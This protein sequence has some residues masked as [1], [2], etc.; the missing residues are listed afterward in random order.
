MCGIVG[1]ASPK[2]IKSKEWLKGSRDLLTY[3]GPD[4]SGEW[5]S[6]DC[7][8]GFGHRRLS[9]IDTSKAGHQPMSDS[10]GLIHIVFNG[11]I[12]NFLEL[13]EEL[14]LLNENFQS[15]TD[16]EVILMAYKVW[17]TDCLSR[18]NG[19]FAFAIFDSI[20]N[21]IFIARDRIGEK[22]L[23]YKVSKGELKF[24][25]EVK[26]LTFDSTITKKINPDAFDLFLTFGYVPGD[27]SMIDGIKK[28]PPAHALIF[29]LK[30]SNLES[31]RYW[32]LP[33][34]FDNKHINQIN[35]ESLIDELDSLLEDSVHRQ[36]QADVPLGV[37]LS[38]GV[39]SSI[40]TAMAV[41]KAKNVKTFT[42]RFPGYKKFDETKHARLI[43]EHF[44]TEHLELEAK[45]LKADL[46]ID[47]AKNFDSPII[48]SSIIPTFLVSQ[49]VSK[50]CKVVL[51]GDGGDELFGGYNYYSRLLFMEKYLS[52]VPLSLRT[53]VATYVNKVL[54]L[55][56][57]KSNWLLASGTDFKKELPMV[58]RFFDPLTRKKILKSKKSSVIS[59]AFFKRHT[60]NHEDLLERA[61][62]MD[63]SHFLT[64]DILVKVDRVSMLNSLEVRSPFL[65]YR[66][67]DFAFGKVPS[68]LKAT[69]SSRKKLLKNLA[70]RILPSSFDHN[71]KQGLIMPLSNWLKDGSWR[72][73]FYDVLTGS[74]CI[75]E[76]N[77]IKKLL[78]GQDNGE[79]NTE[80][81]FGLVFFEIWRQNH[82][83]SV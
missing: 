80:R 33:K 19:M 32:E 60:S 49:L 75:Y 79:N 13:R 82:S 67:V 15:E 22:P 17:G 47:L 16:T 76:R 70:K 51:G 10:T 45:D 73:L 54:S 21:I 39:D 29:D 1:I 74:N 28:L 64:D 65:D 81:L 27:A 78:K 43:A 56:P 7:K 63:L 61:T 5:W 34:P 66:I 55:S 59:E 30:T 20:K 25:S 40:V 6:G 72:D 50:H 68:K 58:T 3:R 44:K 24:A 11:E 23:F 77:V 37:L 31:W 48:D 52:R 83:I 9:I 71:R 41:R 36:M 4:D 2:Q 46:F 57:S 69:D 35:E 42:I 14:K 26:A 8:V 53:R 18:F 62:R 12:Y 38:G